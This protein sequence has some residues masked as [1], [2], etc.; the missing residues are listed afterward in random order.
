MLLLYTNQNKMSK[1][2][3]QF[4]KTPTGISCYEIYAAGPDILP[5][6]AN[7]LQISFGLT[8]EPL[9]DGFDVFYLDC[10]KEGV[11][12]TIGWDIWSGCFIMP[13]YSS[14]ENEKTVDEIGVFLT[15]LLNTF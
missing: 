10:V 12:I 6:I 3:G 15:P 8:P 11:A 1:L 13:L 9:I 7:L 14:T 5:K 2:T 4:C